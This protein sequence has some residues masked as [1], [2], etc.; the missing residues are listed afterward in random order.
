MPS[1]RPRL[2]ALT[3]GALPALALAA[4][5]GAA[6]VR[7]EL[8]LSDF[9]D[10]LMQDMEDTV[11][12][13]EPHIGGKDVAAATDDAAF[14][15]EGLQW[16]ESYFAAKGVDDAVAIAKEGQQHAANVTKALESGDFEGAAAAARA[17]AKTCRTCHDAYRP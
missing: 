14:L 7:A 8:D 13:L 5:L 3:Y 1:H 2:R 6:T 12:A 17:V 16:A 4:A 9:D 11:K 15:R 10:I